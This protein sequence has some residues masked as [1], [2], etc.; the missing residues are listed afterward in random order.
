MSGRE[1]VCEATTECA[2]ER[3]THTQAH[4]H[5]HTHTHAHTHTFV[6]ANALLCRRSSASPH[7][8]AGHASPRTLRM[9][10]KRVGYCS[11]HSCAG[12]QR[13]PWLVEGNV[14]VWS[15]ACKEEV[16]PSSLLNLLFVHSASG[17][18]AHGKRM[19]MS[20]GATVACV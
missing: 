2:F 11:T 9:P 17:K 7:K 5:T 1:R 12:R 8:L 3:A 20:G 19:Y 16:H 10:K 4:T 14:P 15:N 18:K 13:R 6:R